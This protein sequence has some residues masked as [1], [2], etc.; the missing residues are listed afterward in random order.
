MSHKKLVGYKIGSEELIFI[1]QLMWRRIKPYMAIAWLRCYCR[2]LKKKV[3]KN[4][5]QVGMGKLRSEAI[6]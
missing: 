1:S 3:K 4:F 6:Y 2:V 5:L